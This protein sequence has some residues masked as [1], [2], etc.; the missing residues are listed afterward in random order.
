[1]AAGIARAL[2]NNEQVD[3]GILDWSKALDKV[4]HD[5]LP[6]KLDYYGMSYVAW[7]QSHIVFTLH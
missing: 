4:P 2:D 5:R 1:M 6:L 3:I 7:V